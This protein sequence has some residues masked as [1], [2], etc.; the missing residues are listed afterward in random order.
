MCLI[1]HKC[2]VNV[3]SL[4]NL[5]ENNVLVVEKNN[6]IRNWKIPILPTLSP[7]ISDYEEAL[8]SVRWLLNLISSLIMG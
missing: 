5:L 1:L 7:H 4:F 8:G 2:S 3:S 6:S